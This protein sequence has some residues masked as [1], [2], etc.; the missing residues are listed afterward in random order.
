MKLRSRIVVVG[1][2]VVIITPA[3]ASA[4]FGRLGRIIGGAAADAAANEVADRV[5]DAVRCAFDDQKCIDEA[6]DDGQTPVLTDKEGNVITNA[7]GEPVTDPAEAAAQAGATEPPAAAGAV[8]RPGSGAW[9][10]YDFVPGEA[11]LFVDDYSADNVGDFPRRFD[12]V[13]GNWEVVEWQDGRYL[14]ATSAGSVS[15]ELPVALPERFTIEFAASVQHGNA[16]LRVSTAPAY[17]GDR[18][19]AG[20]MPSLQYTTAGLFPKGQGPDVM[21]PRRQGA[22]QESLVTIRIMADGDYMKMY[23]NDQRV[24][25]APNAVFPRTNT[26]FFS[27]GSAAEASPIMIGPMRIAGGG[28]DLYDALEANGRVSTQGIY[29]STNSDVIRPEST[30][31]LKEIGEMLQSHEDLRLTIE[32]HTDSDGDDAHNLDLSD[33]RAAAVKAYLVEEYGVVG[34]RLETQGLGEGS[35]VADN[36]SPEGKQ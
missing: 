24:A 36:G 7:D 31:T 20:S 15:L 28:R 13:A 27:V 25:N 21:T 34:S 33:R 19:Y 10:N 1:L 12:L 35:P 16:Y 14:R 18:S 32:G 26:L 23:S 5:G 17:H 30:A 9:A 11:V 2:S 29:F 6:R 4:Q 3:V 8:E 22:S